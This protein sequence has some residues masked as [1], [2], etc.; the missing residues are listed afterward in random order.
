LDE[1]FF[2]AVG[3]DAVDDGCCSRRWLGAGA[4]GFRG[5]GAFAFADSF[6]G[7]GGGVVAGDVAA[8]GESTSKDESLP[9]TLGDWTLG[10]DAPDMTHLLDQ[11]GGQGGGCVCGGR[12][13]NLQER[14]RAKT[15][16]KA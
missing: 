3:V 11:R 14:V 8:D 12:H 2:G 13:L 1:D 5:S 6:C 4:S 15:R 7:D 10:L 9:E 16:M